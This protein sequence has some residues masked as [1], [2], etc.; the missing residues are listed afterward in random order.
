M[1]DRTSNSS[2][3]IALDCMMVTTS[4]LF[5]LRYSFIESAIPHKGLNKGEMKIQLGSPNHSDSTPLD[6]VIPKHPMKV[7]KYFRGDE[8]QG[9]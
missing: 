3:D 4:D 9:I 6:V 5:E 7:V 8:V 1:W 2:Y